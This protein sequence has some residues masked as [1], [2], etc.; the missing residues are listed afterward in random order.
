VTKDVPDHALVYGNPA[1]IH[2]WMC[3]CGVQLKFRRSGKVE[4]S[5]CSNCSTAYVKDGETVQAREKEPVPQF[6]VR[7]AAVGI[8]R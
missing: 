6:Q 3:L 7:E 1:R 2:G 5:V 4:T 8:L